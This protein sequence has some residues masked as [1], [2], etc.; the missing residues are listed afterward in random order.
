MI[1]FKATYR[2]RLEQRRFLIVRPLDAIFIISRAIEQGSVDEDKDAKLK[3]QSIL[4]SSRVVSLLRYLLVHHT[5]AVQ[6]DF[7][8]PSQQISP[9]AA[10]NVKQVINDLLDPYNETGRSYQ[11]PSVVAPLMHI[12]LCELEPE[13]QVMKLM[14][15][16][17]VF[18]LPFCQ[19]KLRKIFEIEQSPIS[20]CG[21]GIP[22]DVVAGLFEGAKSAVASENTAWPILLS[23]LDDR[24]AR[25][26]IPLSVRSEGQ[27]LI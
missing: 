17:D 10:F 23:I 22:T 2:F 13:N 21:D 3:L 4:T 8:P 12:D 24:I 15:M 14:Q 19:L 26:V 5:G 7:F 6:H 11:C 27:W 1:S 18:S 20:D 16:A 25:Q 9:A